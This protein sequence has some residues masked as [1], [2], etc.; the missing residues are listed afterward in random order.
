MATRKRPPLSE[1][2]AEYVDGRVSGRLVG[3]PLHYPA[4]PSDDY[5]KAMRRI[6]REMERAYR[7]E[8]LS[9]HEQVLE[10][11]EVASM[12]AS[13][14]S[15]L[16]I[17]L[18]ALRARFSKL[19]TERAPAIVSS[20]LERV[21][22]SQQRILGASLKELSGGLTL[23]TDVMPTA[24][25]EALTAATNENVSLIKSIQSRYHTQVEGIV[26]RSIQPGGRGA[27]DIKEGLMRYKGVTE[28][29]AKIIATD[30]TRK[31]TAAMNYERSKSLGIKSFKWQHSSGGKEARPLH[32]NV[33]N[34]KI[35]SYDD[36]PV[37][38]EKTGER[39]LP[40]QLINCRCVAVPVLDW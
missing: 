33:L 15:Q 34:G 4:A 23:K 11:E 39:G 8:L 21:N 5:D 2:R 16:R 9:V 13:L 38:D 29:R 28:R 20:M 1:K 27:A 17:R 24:L 12:D 22:Q 25:S 32:K 30:Q 40:G 26:M 6:I 36:L 10:G 19:F 7:E 14:A 31:V 37:I 35:F 3:Q 18:N